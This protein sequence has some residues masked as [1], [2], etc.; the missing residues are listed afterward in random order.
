MMG[1]HG[2]EKMVKGENLIA[3]G[4]KVGIRPF[5][6][7]DVDEWCA[8]P[9]HPDPLF[10]DYNTPRMTER[11]RDMWYSSHLMRPGHEMYALVDAN[12]QLIGRLF[13]RQINTAEKSA[14]M[15]VD[16]RSDRLERGYGKDALAAFCRYFFLEREFEIFKLDVAAYNFRAQ[17][18]YEKI[19]WE[20]TGHHWNTY[21]S[22]F[23][24]QVFTDPKY[25]RIRR[26]FKLGPGYVSILHYDM[27]LT[28]NRWLERQ[29]FEI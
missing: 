21:P 4:K 3:Q 19:G 6:R 27:V 16:L 1:L 11:E 23:M 24:S 29:E 20:Y 26:Y 5:S 17:H 2:Y 13:L 10:R 12:G 28:R 22:S 14:V 7:G 15:G 8:W 25:E 9:D 18:V